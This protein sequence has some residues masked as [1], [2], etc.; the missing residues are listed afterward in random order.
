MDDIQV[1]VDLGSAASKVELLEVLKQLIT[2]SL[3]E[4]WEK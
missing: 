2:K 3:K 4:I 1:I